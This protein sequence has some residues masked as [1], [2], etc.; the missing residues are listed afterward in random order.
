MS[1]YDRM[2]AT[3]KGEETIRWLMKSARKISEKMMAIQGS[4]GDLWLNFRGPEGEDR[5]ST[6]IVRGMEVT[7][8]ACDRKYLSLAFGG[9]DWIAD[10]LEEL[11]PAIPVE[12]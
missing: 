11:L 10:H 12:A 9:I 5:E 1:S 3:L 2:A 8:R 4:G 7:L 6:M